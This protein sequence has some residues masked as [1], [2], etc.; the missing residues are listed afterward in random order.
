MSE[1]I[2]RITQ[3]H[4]EIIT[5]Q[6][7]KNLPEECGGFLGGRDYQI[8][9]IQP[10]FNQHL[11]NKTH[12]F[13]FTSEDTERALK[14]FKKHDMDYYGLYHSHP[15]GVAVPS[16]KDISTGHKF[17]FII[18]LTGENDIDM[19]AWH[20]VNRQ[21]IPVPLQIISNK[22]FS[23]IDIHNESASSRMSSGGTSKNRTMIDE[24]SDLSKKIQEMK[25]ENLKYERESPRDW[26]NSDFSTLA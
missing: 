13:A 2:F 9:A 22:N 18:G 6:A 4:Y 12:T 16:D 15:S 3:R 8:M 5:Q 20:V 11:Y 10:I 1:I 21:A 7:V 23:A 24:A 26:Y 25:S 14:F 19:R 17:H